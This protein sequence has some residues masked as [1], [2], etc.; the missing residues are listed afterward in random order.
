VAT[1]LSTIVCTTRASISGRGSNHVDRPVRH[2][3][4]QFLAF[5]ITLAKA[6][7]TT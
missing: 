2:P 1:G 4:R 5:Q 6:E 3:R 7:P